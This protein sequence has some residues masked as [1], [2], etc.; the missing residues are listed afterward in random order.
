MPIVPSKKV[1]AKYNGE[2]LIQLIEKE[3]EAIKARVV[4]MDEKLAGHIRFWDPVAY[5]PNLIQ[6]V[7][8]LYLH[9]Y[10]HY[11]VVK[12]QLA[13]IQIKGGI[14]SVE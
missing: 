7:H 5:H 10:H 14:T 2:E 6:A 3:T 9:E 8:L 12:E 1:V 13:V 4:H 11:L